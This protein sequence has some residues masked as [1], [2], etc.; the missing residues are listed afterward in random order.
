MPITT[1]FNSILDW[2]RNEEEPEEYQLG[3]S[4]ADNLEELRQE[5]KKEGFSLEENE[6]VYLSILAHVVEENREGLEMLAEEE[7]AEKARI[8]ED[9]S[10]EEDSSVKIKTIKPGD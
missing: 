5:V 9:T 8:E 2:F 3:E 1:Y 7:L 6:E 4:M 10:L